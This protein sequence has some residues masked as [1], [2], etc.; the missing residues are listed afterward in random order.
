M[1]LNLSFLNYRILCDTLNFLL[2][3]HAL[4]WTITFRAMTV[5]WE[6]AQCSVNSTTFSIAIN[7]AV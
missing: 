3:T 7:A 1:A 2:H 4:P 5:L 6:G